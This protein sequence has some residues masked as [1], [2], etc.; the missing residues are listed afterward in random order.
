MSEDG[1]IR[2]TTSIYRH[3]TAAALLGMTLPLCPMLNAHPTAQLTKI[4]PRNPFFCA[5][6][7]LY[8]Q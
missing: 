3:L 8:S 2:G 7:G 4:P 5:A 1:M 6:H